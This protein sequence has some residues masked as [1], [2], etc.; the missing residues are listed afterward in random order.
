MENKGF[1]CIAGLLILLLSAAG[2]LYLVY[3]NTLFEQVTQPTPTA[4][5]N[6]T[7]TPQASPTIQP[8][9]DHQATAQVGAKIE[10]AS[11][12]AQTA[13]TNLDTA[14]RNY[15]AAKVQADA[16]IRAAE[17]TADAQGRT[18]AAL[19]ELETVKG[20][21]AVQ[22]AQ[23]QLEIVRAQTDLFASQTELYRQE[24]ANQE[25]ILQVVMVVAILAVVIAA[26][27]VALRGR[28]RRESEPVDESDDEQEEDYSWLPDFPASVPLKRYKDV[29]PVKSLVAIARGVVAGEPFTHD[30][31]VRNKKVI[32]EGKFM[33][34]QRL[35]V[36]DLAE[37]ANK[38]NHRLGCIPNEKA[39]RFF[40]RIS[41]KTTPPPSQPV[42]VPAVQPGTDT[43]RHD[44][45]GLGENWSQL[46]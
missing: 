20:E 11:I 26:L 17:I 44:S 41:D 30:H 7:P 4:Q 42:P 28:V 1:G 23:L 3:G 2:V 22:L 21:Y 35:M 5:P 25:F 6:R 46:Q 14:N 19:I 12:E 13:K 16:A 34:L 43:I 45:D 18:D 37:W 10:A 15:E 32:S 36:P 38:T 31:F 39:I 24:R 33:T 8:T 40:K 9:P 27:V 29:I